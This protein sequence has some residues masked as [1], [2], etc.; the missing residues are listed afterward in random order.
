M[1]STF[2]DAY[3]ISFSDFIYQS[4]CCG[5]SLELPRLVKAIQMS[6]HNIYFYKEVDK[7][8]LVQ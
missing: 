5:Y 8:T 6:C 7:S 3:A 4:I 1:R 2:N